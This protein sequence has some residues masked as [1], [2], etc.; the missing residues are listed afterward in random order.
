MNNWVRPCKNISNC[1]WLLYYLHYFIFVLGRVSSSNRSSEVMNY[2]M[3]TAD[4]KKEEVELEKQRM[5]LEDRRIAMQE[6]KLQM[7]FERQQQMF[8]MAMNMHMPMQNAPI[9]MPLQNA[10][11]MPMQNKPMA[12]PF[13]APQP[14]ATTTTAQDVDAPEDD[15]TYDFY[16]MWER[17]S[18]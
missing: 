4:L 17:Y 18:T 14:V 6:R 15:R 13:Q 8:P 2:L 7:E 10:P 11:I 5:K 12:V 1:D 3:Y 16:T 9:T